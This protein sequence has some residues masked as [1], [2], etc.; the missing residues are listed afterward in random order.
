MTCKGFSYYHNLF[1]K[2]YLFP[3]SEFYLGSFLRWPEQPAPGQAEAWAIFWCLSQTI[4]RELDWKWAAGT[5][6]VPTWDVA[7]AGS[8]LTYSTTWHWT[9][10]EHFVIVWFFSPPPFF[11][12]CGWVYDC[13]P[14]TDSWV[15]CVTWSGLLMNLMTF[16]ICWHF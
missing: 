12:K 2:I 4:I 5:W 13:S 1:Q 9:P 14:S 15:S 16:K 10:K 11:L 8:G 3:K 6:T 7:I